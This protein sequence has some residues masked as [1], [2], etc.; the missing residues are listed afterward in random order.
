M[1]RLVLLF[2]EKK[3]GINE[4]DAIEGREIANGKI[5]D[6]VVCRGIESGAV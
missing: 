4:G 2:K 5:Y 1:G 6:G 3:G